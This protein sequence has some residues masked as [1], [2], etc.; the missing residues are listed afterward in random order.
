MTRSPL[1]IFALLLSAFAAPGCAYFQSPE[2][3]DGTAI[4]TTN[5]EVRGDVAPREVGRHARLA[6]RLHAGFERFFAT[7]T[8]GQTTICIFS[9]RGSYQSF[10]RDYRNLLS[11][12]DWEVLSRTRGCHSSFHDEILFYAGPLEQRVLAHEIAH[13]F[14]HATDADA[15]PWVHEGMAGL[16][17]TIPPEELAVVRDVAPVGDTVSDAIAR[18]ALE[19]GSLPRLS[20]LLTPSFNVFYRIPYDKELAAS[21][22]GYLIGER[23]GGIRDGGDVIALADRIAADPEPWEAS[24]REWLE[25][26]PRSRDVDVAFR[27]AADDPLVRRTLP[28]V[29]L[30]FAPRGQRERELVLSLTEDEDA[31]VAAMARFFY[32][33]R[34]PGRTQRLLHARRVAALEL[35]RRG[36]RRV[37]R[38]LIAALDGQRRTRRR[39][40]RSDDP[41][42]LL[43]RIVLLTG[44]DLS[45]ILEEARHARRSGV[46]LNAV[47][48]RWWDENR[49]EFPP[50]I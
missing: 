14:V 37:V 48:A 16:L 9:E 39:R 30:R 26:W 29:V 24:W 1:P 40:R 32:E 11:E 49:L 22:I 44:G 5:Y 12:L 43:I 10:L 25:G 27:R 36:D 46:E 28:E 20:E 45:T 4:P 15:A 47:L 6:E 34:I 18:A 19:D 21:F 38:R 13:R 17:E 3:I 23:V 8:T 31:R 7:E 42:E 35:G 50:Q 33:P 2:F 41:F